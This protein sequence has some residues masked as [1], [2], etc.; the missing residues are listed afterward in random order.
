V[1]K[2]Q[3]GHFWDMDFRYNPEIS[4]VFMHVLH[5]AHQSSR[6]CICKD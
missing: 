2:G 1:R 3:N 4:L 5:T 6:F